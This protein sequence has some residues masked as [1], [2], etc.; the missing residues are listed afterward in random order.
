[1]VIHFQTVGELAGL[2]KSG[3]YTNYPDRHPR[4]DSLPST[5]QAVADCAPFSCYN[6]RFAILGRRSQLR[7]YNI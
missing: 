1:M 5:D 3:P 6:L 7:L 4:V 2:T